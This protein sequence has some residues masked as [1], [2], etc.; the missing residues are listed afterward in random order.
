MQ[1]GMREKRTNVQRI[2]QWVLRCPPK[3]RRRKKRNKDSPYFPKGIHPKER[4]MLQRS[5][6]NI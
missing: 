3:K 6:K 4:I 2:K 1:R 5:T